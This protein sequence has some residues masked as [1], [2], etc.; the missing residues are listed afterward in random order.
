MRRLAPSRSPQHLAGR[1]AA[2]LATSCPVHD[3]ERAQMR[4]FA[5]DGAGSSEIMGFFG[6][7]R[8]VVR[9]HCEGLSQTRVTQ[10]TRLLAVLDIAENSDLPRAVLA[11]QLGYRNAASLGV[12]LTRAR[13]LR[14][15]WGA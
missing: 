15:R 8:S 13:K 6:R 11:Q 4:A 12:V 14:R 5:A 2:S 3:D 1:A 10:R 9:R 7:S